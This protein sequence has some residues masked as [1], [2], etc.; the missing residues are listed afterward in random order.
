MKSF[1]LLSILSYDLWLN[2]AKL[3]YYQHPCLWLL[4]HF[5]YNCASIESVHLRCW[6]NSSVKSQCLAWFIRRRNCSNKL[7]I[8]TRRRGKDY[9]TAEQKNSEFNQLHIYVK[10]FQFVFLKK[11]KRVRINWCTLFGRI[12]SNCHRVK[13]NLT[14]WKSWAD[15]T[16]F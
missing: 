10:V 4:L 5:E 7:K 2:S 9:Y 1:R 16:I 12:Y 11:R 3:W 8:F 15:M 13:F 6:I 14:L